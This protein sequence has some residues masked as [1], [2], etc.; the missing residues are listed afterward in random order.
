MHL[1]GL[2]K[3]RPASTHPKAEVALLHYVFYMSVFLVLIGVFVFL[4]KWVGMFGV[5]AAV[6]PVEPDFSWVAGGHGGPPRQG[7]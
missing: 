1:G 2:E 5:L 4:E 7:P 3:C 6:G